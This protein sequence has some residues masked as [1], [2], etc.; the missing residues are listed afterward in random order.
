MRFLG[1]SEEVRAADLD[2]NDNRPAEP[3]VV[4]TPADS[5]RH[6]T[7]NPVSGLRN[8]DSAAWAGP[9]CGTLKPEHS[10]CTQLVV[11]H[12]RFL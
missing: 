7:V 1:V 4:R 9:A 10:K 5:V 3:V 6:F 8:R 11:G 12:R 2:F